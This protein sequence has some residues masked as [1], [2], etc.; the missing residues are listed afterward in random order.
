MNAEQIALISQQVSNAS[1]Q[2]SQGAAGQASSIEEISSSVDEMV[3]SIQQ[4]ASHARETEQITIRS[5]SE[6]VNW[7]A[8]TRE[9]VESNKAISDKIKIINDIAFQTNILA[10]NAAIEAARAGEHGKGFSVVAAEVRKLAEIS[11]LAADDIGEFSQSNLSLTEASYLK[12]NEILPHI[13]Q[14]ATFIKGIKVA[15]EEQNNGAT[16]IND[17]IQQFNSVT[18]QNAAASEELATNASHL[19]FQAEQLRDVMSFFKIK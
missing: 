14:S 5:Q 3:S 11:K 9:M 10:L 17:A 15:S 13:E 1:N 19:A 6:L 8:Q 2:L 18:Q 16:L 12:M 7:T 4:N